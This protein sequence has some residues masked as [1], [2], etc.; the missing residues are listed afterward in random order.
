MNKLMFNTNSLYEEIVNNNQIDISFELFYAHLEYLYYK[1]YIS[2]PNTVSQKI[3]IFNNFPF[4][5][6]KKYEQLK[7]KK[8]NCFDFKKENNHN[9]LVVIMLNQNPTE[10]IFTEEYSEFEKADFNNPIFGEKLLYL[11]LI[12]LKIEERT[13]MVLEVNL[14]SCKNEKE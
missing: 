6:D 7:N 14:I 1:N 11:N 12:Y 2:Y 9:P 13:K 10:D 3:S 8:P 4:I 5:S